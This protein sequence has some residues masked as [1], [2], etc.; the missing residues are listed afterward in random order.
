MQA[1][2]H[3]IDELKRQLQRHFSDGLVTIVGS[4]LSAAVGLPTMSDL[5]AQLRMQMPQLCTGAS[6]DSWASIDRLLDIGRDLETALANVSAD[7]DLIPLVVGATADMV[8]DAESQ[9]IRRVL[10]GEIELPFSALLPKLL[11]ADSVAHVVTS[12]YDRLIEFA[13]EIAGV[14]VDTGF[15]GSNY[16]AFSPKRSAESLRTVLPR[17]DR[18]GFRREI[19]RHVSLHK[20]HGSV[21]WF[22][23]AGS[24]VRCTL[25][26][27]STRLM[28]TPG[29]SK[30]RLGYNS[31]FDYQRA[32]ANR[33]IDNAAR[34]LIIGY[35]FNDDQLETHLRPQ[36][37]NGRP[38][39][40]LTK[41]LTANAARI[42]ADNPS[43]LALVAHQRTDGVQGTKCVVGTTEAVFDHV[44]FWNLSTF[45]REVLE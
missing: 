41:D 2:P 14:P 45:V 8:L 13:T 21:D 23:H 19:T 10:R 16:G 24:P 11:F 43:V 18:I 15:V 4:G 28:I 32:E 27:D 22:V 38:C 9:A 3:D 40:L 31:P 20:P 7:D 5:A 17:R 33:A 34:F 26:L 1:P 36:L 35:G 25:P 6:R 29:Q 39:V 37:E 12:N 44:R 42:V 30:Y